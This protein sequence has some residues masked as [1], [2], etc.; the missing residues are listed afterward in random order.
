M[1]LSYP[2][3]RRPARVAFVRIAGIV[4]PMLAG[5]VYSLGFAPYRLWPLSLVAAAVFLGLVMRPQGVAYGL[6]TGL[7]FGLGV[8]APS[9]SFLFYGLDYSIPLAV[10]WPLAV[11]VGLAL[12]FA[13]FG[14]A[15]SVSRL[16]FPAKLLFVA[17]ALWVVLEWLRHQGTLA[18]PWLAFGYTQI[19]ASPLAGYAPVFGILGVT[20]FAVLAAGA[21][22]LL[23]DRARRRQ[24]IL[25][26]AGL[27]GS[28]AALRDIPWVEPAGSPISATALQ[29]NVPTDEKFPRQYVQRSLDRYL[30]F[31]QHSAA[32]LIVMPESALPLLDSDLPADFR[33]QLG[34]IAESN[35]GD[36]V[37]GVLAPDST[38]K[39]YHSSA[40]SVGVSGRQRYDK[41][42]LLPF[43]EFVPLPE[44]LR[45]HFERAARAPLLDTVP[46][47]ANQGPLTLAGAR[48][49]IRM[50][51]EDAFGNEQ[52]A[53]IAE[54]AF[55][56]SLVND[57]WYGHPL[58]VEQHLQVAQARALEAGRPVLRI[59]NTGWT[60]LI[61][62]DGRL[63]T[64]LKPHVAGILTT[65]IQPTVGLTPYIR[66]GDRPIGILAGVMLLGVYSHTRRVADNPLPGE[67]SYA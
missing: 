39:A 64:A 52:R 6:Y 21:L 56:L 67:R 50:C 19:D 58:P 20:L 29:G 38:G 41:V 51:F 3:G 65:A 55:V 26:L 16:P 27:F 45:R 17:P 11:I 5:V 57:D 44:T 66:F 9:L 22:V 63:E 48:V 10:L 33:H 35:G 12:L 30:S 2:V 23:A 37:Y 59:S 32:R 13:L 24:A 53:A 34:Q 40:V 60:A 4:A 14:A 49:A 18:L 42:H 15:L 43:A 1:S 7:L 8:Y 47:A 61:R 62:P 31:A 54:S 46:G 25:L 36:L 28:G